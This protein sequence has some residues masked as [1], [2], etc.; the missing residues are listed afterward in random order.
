MAGGPCRWVDSPELIVPAACVQVVGNDALYDVFGL[1]R[2]EA[3][4]GNLDIMYNARIASL[5][6]VRSLRAVGGRVAINDNPSLTVIS[7]LPVVA[8]RDLVIRN[9][10]RLTA[11]N[12]LAA[13]TTLRGSLIIADNPLLGGAWGLQQLAMVGL[14]AKIQRNAVLNSLTFLANVRPVFSMVCANGQTATVPTAYR[15]WVTDGN[16]QLLSSNTACNGNCSCPAA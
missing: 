7:S 14:A 1:D 10:A 16:T 6:S 8:S 9:N 11:V 2:L 13:L 5:T 3:V 4:G 12:G 15:T